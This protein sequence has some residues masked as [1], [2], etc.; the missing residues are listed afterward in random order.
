MVAGGWLFISTFFF[1]R[2]LAAQTNGWF[3]GSAIVIT[4]LAALTVD[5]ARFVNTALSVW[6][7][8]S[9]VWVFRL[10]EVPRFNDVIVAIIVFTLSWV[11]IAARGD[12][13]K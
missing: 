2:G 8:L 13:A 1:E 5:G 6:L 7:F 10:P 11:P 3:A 4:A 9:A 12:R